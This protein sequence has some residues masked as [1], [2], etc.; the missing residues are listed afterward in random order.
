MNISDLKSGTRLYRKPSDDGAAPDNNWYQV[1]IWRDDTVVLQPQ[2][3]QAG[4][5]KQAVTMKV[6]LER[7]LSEWQLE[8]PWITQT[9]E[10][11]EDSKKKIQL[12]KPI[13]PEVKNTPEEPKESGK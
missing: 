9:P 2:H 4:K 10:P 6:S 13:K 8:K 3:S 1:V 7:V 12:D 5:G 11:V